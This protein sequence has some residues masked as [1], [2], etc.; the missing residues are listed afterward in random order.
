[1]A[2]AEEDNVVA[3]LAALAVSEDDVE[4]RRLG[5][6]EG[7]LEWYPRQL[8]GRAAVAELAVAE[9]G[10]IETALMEDVLRRPVAMGYLPE[11]H[12]PVLELWKSLFEHRLRWSVG[13]L[14]SHRYSLW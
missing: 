7:R 2:V 6:G 5:W 9:E 1:M 14:V 10:K 12:L 8:V 11:P 3:E 4:G 13:S